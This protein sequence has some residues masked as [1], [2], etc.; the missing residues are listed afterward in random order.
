MGKNNILKNWSSC[1]GAGVPA[2][3]AD[4]D[5]RAVVSCENDNA[6]NRS[7]DGAAENAE[8]EEISSTASEY[9]CQKKYSAG[10]K[11]SCIAL[12]NTETCADHS[13]FDRSIR[14]FVG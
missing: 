10:K 13:D 14:A 2:A 12:M 5:K 4:S 9:I 7:D 3:W 1:K 11:M 8:Y 6:E